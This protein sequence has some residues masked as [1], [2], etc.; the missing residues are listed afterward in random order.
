MIHFHLIFIYLFTQ[1]IG[2]VVMLCVCLCVV[3]LSGYYIQSEHCIFTNYDGEVRITP[4]A[5]APCTVNTNRILCPTHIN[6][7]Q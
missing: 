7:G 4:I 6:H 2:T 1:I 5:N 3:V